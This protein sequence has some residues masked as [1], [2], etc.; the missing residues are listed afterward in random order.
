M[1][2][3][4]LDNGNYYVHIPKGEIGDPNDIPEMLRRIPGYVFDPVPTFLEIFDSE[5]GTLV[6]ARARGGEPTCYE[7]NDIEEVICAVRVCPDDTISFLAS[8]AG[9]YVLIVYPWNRESPP[10]RLS[11]F[12]E[13]IAAHPDITRHI[14]EHGKLLLGPEAVREIKRAFSID[15]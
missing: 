13:P 8:D 2:I 4:P 9:R 7:F 15:N 10:M 6:F 5:D 14:E 3:C 12:G 1:D 11:E